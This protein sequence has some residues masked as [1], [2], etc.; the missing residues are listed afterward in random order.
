MPSFLRPFPLVICALL[1][2]AILKLPY[3][4]YQFLR[5]AVTVWGIGC[6]YGVTH[7][8]QENK[9][10]GTVLLL[11]GGI[12]ILYNPLIPIHLTREIWFY[13]NLLSI[14]GVL[15]CTYLTHTV[16]DKRANNQT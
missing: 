12:T 2:L 8:E 11:T 9:S 14:P 4:Y 15:I 10:A 13:L 3:G 5:I 1:G 7:Q 16:K 6:I